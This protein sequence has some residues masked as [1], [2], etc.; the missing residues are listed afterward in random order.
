[1]PMGGQ[2]AAAYGQPTNMYSAPGQA[3][4]SVRPMPP[5]SGAPMSG[6]VVP[7]GGSFQPSAG[8]PAPPKKPASRAI[9]IV[10]PET[11]EEVVV[12]KKAEPPPEAPPPEA[13]PA[14]SAPQP[15]A[16]PPLTAPP[17]ADEPPASSYVTTAIVITLG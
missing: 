7:V 13:P 2:Q 9:A 10:N 6:G 12:P 14:D 8:A 4:G 16:S 1:M 15:D 11:N 3:A 5:R 17:A